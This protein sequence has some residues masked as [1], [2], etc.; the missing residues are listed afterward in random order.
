MNNICEKTVKLI[1]II[2]SMQRIFISESVIVLLS[3]FTQ[4]RLQCPP[5]IA[6]SYDD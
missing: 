1:D 6:A 5:G 4:T 3:T 2:N